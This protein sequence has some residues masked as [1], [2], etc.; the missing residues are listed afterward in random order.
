MMSY[1][2]SCICIYIYILNFAKFLRTPFLQ[3]TSGRLL[4]DSPLVPG[5]LVASNNCI[6]IK[7]FMAIFSGL[8]GYRGIR[9]KK[10]LCRPSNS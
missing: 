6:C 9:S 5:Q 8:S 3:N 4:L 10:I 1:S 7:L 2:Y